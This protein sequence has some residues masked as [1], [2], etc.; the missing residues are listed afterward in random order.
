[1]SRG[2]FAFAYQLVDTTA[3]QRL[4]GPLRCAGVVVLDEAVVETLGLDIGKQKGQHVLRRPRR[5][6]KGRLLTFLSGMI[7]TFWTWPVVSKIWRSTSSV[8]RGSRPPT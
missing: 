7:L 4:H 1:M 6:T 2:V 3:V 8:T 5:G